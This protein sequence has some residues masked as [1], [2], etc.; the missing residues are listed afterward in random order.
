MVFVV[1]ILRGFVLES[2]FSIRAEFPIRVWSALSGK[3]RSS[4]GQTVV[5]SKVDDQEK[6]V[7]SI[8]NSI[9]VDEFYA[10]LGYRSFSGNSTIVEGSIIQLARLDA[11]VA[12]VPNCVEQTKDLG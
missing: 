2:I 8:R 10:S 9:S 6:R 12:T 11:L 4:N 7:C 1:E 5:Y 3:H